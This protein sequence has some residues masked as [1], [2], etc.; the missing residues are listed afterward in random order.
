MCTALRVRR[1]GPNPEAQ[2]AALMALQPPGLQPAPVSTGAVAEIKY[3]E[4]GAAI[5]LPGPMSGRGPFESVSGSVS[6]SASKQ[7]SQ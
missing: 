2:K 7:S 5:G 6:W 3:T 1:R 4:V